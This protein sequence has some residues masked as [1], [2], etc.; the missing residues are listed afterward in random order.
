MR[1]HGW[2]AA[3][4]SLAGRSR[5]RGRDVVAADVQVESLDS[6]VL[7]SASGLSVGAR[8]QDP[9]AVGSLPNFGGVWEILSGL[10]KNGGTVSQSGKNVQIDFDL[11]EV[12]HVAGKGRIKHNGE[13]LGKVQLN[14]LG[15]ISVKA[16]LTVSL[17]DENHF[18]GTVT[19]TLPLLGKRT[20]H[21]GGTKLGS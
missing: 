20:Y 16:K 4:G 19:A 7:L 2:N 13:L 21:F 10:S 18:Q 12:G 11:G 6:R 5:R 15:V 3:W 1:S 8:T 14:A 9:T 17:T